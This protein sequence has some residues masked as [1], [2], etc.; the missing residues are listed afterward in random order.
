MSIG[1]NI[2]RLRKEKGWTQAEFGEM[3]GVSNQ[4]VSKWESEMSMPDVMILPQIS[5]LFGISIESLYE[6]ADDGDFI[7]DN[8]KNPISSDEDNRVLVILDEH[9]DS[10]V[11]TRVPVKAIL[12]LLA[13]E[14]VIDD[15][16]LADEEVDFV[17]KIIGSKQTLFENSKGDRKIRITIEDYET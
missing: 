1:E 7:I 13:N 2:A 9:N 5:K 17:R 4:A 14:D 8:P 3:L 10:V 12:A 11:K 15:I 16:D 6:E